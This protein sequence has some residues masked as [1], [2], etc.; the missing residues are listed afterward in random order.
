MKGV[1]DGINLFCGVHKPLATFVE[2]ANAKLS[3]HSLEMC[4]K[5]VVDDAV[6]V[7]HLVLC[8]L[9]ADDV[10]R[11]A[12]SDLSPKVNKTKNKQIRKICKKFC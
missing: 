6:G 12:G 7:E 4:I 2:E 3:E 11:A 8:N 1:V 10:A 9:K 5:R